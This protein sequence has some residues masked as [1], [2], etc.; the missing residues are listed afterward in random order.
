M[1]RALRS[2]SP[3]TVLLP[4]LGFL[5]MIGYAEFKLRSAVE[6]ELPIEG[7]DP[8][9]PIRGHYLQFRFKNVLA[10]TWIPSL[11]SDSPDP[12]WSAEYACIRPIAGQLH[13][14]VLSHDAPDPRCTQ[15]FP[16]RFVQD[17][18]RY[19]IQQDSGPEL[20]QALREQRVTLRVALHPNQEPLFTQLLVD[21]RP[22]T[23]VISTHVIPHKAPTTP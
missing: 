9:D 10:P 14:L 11:T 13:E 15:D 16:L 17:V 6:V 21:S 19:Y 4:L 12:I 20:E 8:R 5:G 23:E 7:F 3:F 18:H 2:L 1:I 22:W